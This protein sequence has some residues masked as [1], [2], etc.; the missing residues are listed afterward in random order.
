MINDKAINNIKEVLSLSRGV[1]GGHIVAPPIATST[2]CLK[3]HRVLPKVWMVATPT[4]HCLKKCQVRPKGVDG[5][6][7]DTTLFKEVPS[8]A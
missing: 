5:G 4:Q 2:H 7:T 1:D 8:L 3:K 6:H